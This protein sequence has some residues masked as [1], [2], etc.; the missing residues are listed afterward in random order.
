MLLKNFTSSE[1]YHLRD[2]GN[3]IFSDASFVVGWNKGVSFFADTVKKGR[4]QLEVSSCQSLT[5][6]CFC[7]KIQHW[8]NWWLF[9]VTWA[10]EKTCLNMFMALSMNFKCKGLTYNK[11]N[12][13]P[14][15]LSYLSRLSKRN[16]TLQWRFREW[17]LWR[18]L[19]FHN[20][21]GRGLLVTSPFLFS[22][23]SFSAAA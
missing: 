5:A 6:D 1:K 4:H 21:L 22:C 7:K 11:A 19:Y 14:T 12:F 10:N 23:S 8:R 20:F 9:R 16:S 2:P 13:L 18:I 17:K 15:Y 3:K